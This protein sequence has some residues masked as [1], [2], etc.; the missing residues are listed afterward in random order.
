MIY[1]DISNPDF[2]P[3]L[4]SNMKRE[5]T[6]A[7]KGDNEKVRLDF[8]VNNVKLF[9]QDG[10][11][12]TLMLSILVEDGE[13]YW[14]LSI[15]GLPATTVIPSDQLCR[16]LVDH[17]MGL[18]GVLVGENQDKQRPGVRHFLKRIV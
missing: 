18:D 15:G 17:I 5:A 4:A 3:T 9:E 12:Y 13:R 2:L 8:L 7:A 1:I 6:F 11:K 10:K 14:H 16:Y